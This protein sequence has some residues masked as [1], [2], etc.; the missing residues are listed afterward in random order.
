[1]KKRELK[2]IK[3]ALEKEKMDKDE[4]K[5]QIENIQVIKKCA[6]SWQNDINARRGVNKEK[7]LNPI[8]EHESNQ[9]QPRSQK[10]KKTKSRQKLHRERMK[11]NIKRCGYSDKLIY[12]Q[13]YEGK[14]PT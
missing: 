13:T 6:R 2:K 1:M 11:D 3:K 4:I 8:N 10:K 5:E 7:N 14:K 12:F 9:K